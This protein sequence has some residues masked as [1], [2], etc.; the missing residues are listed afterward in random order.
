ME[1]SQKVKLCLTLA[2]RGGMLSFDM[3]GSISLPPHV[4]LLN[5]SDDKL[6][7]RYVLILSIKDIGLVSMNHFE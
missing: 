4:G 2:F 5:S 3:G 1:A 6:V 7:V